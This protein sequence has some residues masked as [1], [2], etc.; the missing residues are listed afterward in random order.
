[1][2]DE[3]IRHLSQDSVLRPLLAA[4][5]FPEPPK[6]QGLFP[7]LLACLISQQLSA[8]AAATIHAR[9]LQLFPNHHP[10][11]Q[12]LLALPPER[13]RS[14]GLSTQK[15]RYVLATAR[16]FLEHPHLETHLPT[17]SDEEVLQK[18]TQIKG[19]GTWTAQMVLIF[20]L[21]RPDVFPAGDGGIRQAMQTLYRLPSEGP[22]LQSAMECRAE[23]WRP[24]RSYA[25]RFLW[26]WKDQAP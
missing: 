25:C 1:M 14:V 24:F 5:P 16:F 9:F 23:R 11:P 2:K 21:Q 17:L 10:T 7:D 12:T 18:L 19:V 15:A 8:K 26:H 13:L 6:S 3:V 4:L 20:T 22:A